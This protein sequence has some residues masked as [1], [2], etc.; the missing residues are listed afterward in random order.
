[1]PL[2]DHA[3]LL[4]QEL[5]GQHPWYAEPLEI[6]ATRARRHLTN[7]RLRVE[8]RL[9]LAAHSRH[10]VDGTDC[11]LEVDSAPAAVEREREWQTQLDG[12]QVRRPD[13]SQARRPDGSQVRRPDGEASRSAPADSEAGCVQGPPVVFENDINLMDLVEDMQDIYRAFHANIGAQ[14]P[15]PTHLS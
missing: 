2:F 1:M 13:G 15:N 7:E 10:A 5:L 12:S 8:L 4:L 9:R 3:A 14:T 6:A 11:V